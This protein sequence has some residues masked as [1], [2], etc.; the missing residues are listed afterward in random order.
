[1]KVDTAEGANGDSNGGVSATEVD[2]MRTAPGWLLVDQ[3]RGASKKI[4]LHSAW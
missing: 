2:S 3:Y 4:E 1:V